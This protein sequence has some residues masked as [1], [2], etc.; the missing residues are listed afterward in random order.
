L[1]WIM[2]QNIFRL[3]WLVD[4]TLMEAW[5]MLWHP[6]IR[7]DSTNN[8]GTGAKWNMSAL[9][10]NFASLQWETSRM[11]CSGRCVSSGSIY[12]ARLLAERYFIC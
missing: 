10:G 4:A 2:F 1:C 3:A 8:R 9:V 12:K 6:I 5:G 7:K 11:Q